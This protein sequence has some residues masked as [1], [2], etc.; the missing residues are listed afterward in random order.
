MTSTELDT[1]EKAIRQMSKYTAVSASAISQR[2]HVPVEQ[3]V[4]AAQLRERQ[5]RRCLR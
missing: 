3:V 4:Q 2:L 5:D 1:I